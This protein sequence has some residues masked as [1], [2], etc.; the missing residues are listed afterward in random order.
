VS[1][2]LL[3][4]I[5]VPLFWSYS[6]CFWILFVS[7]LFLFSTETIST[8]LRFFWSIFLGFPVSFTW[9]RYWARKLGT[10]TCIRRVNADG[11]QFALK[12]KEKAGKIN[13][14]NK[15]KQNN[16]TKTKSKR[17]GT[18]KLW[19]R[20]TVSHSTRSQI[21][22]C[23][24]IWPMLPM[25]CFTVFPLSL[26]SNQSFFTCFFLIFSLGKIL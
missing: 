23:N 16:K 4:C 21:M 6:Y 10:R 11:F 8:R 5:L 24:I 2:L 12:K 3:I 19:A 20:Y 18:T 14:T 17:I 25:F 9:E 22:K 26:L 15:Q 7:R 1:D 13:K